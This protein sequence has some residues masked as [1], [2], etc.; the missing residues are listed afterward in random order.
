MTTTAPTSTIAPFKGDPL[1]GRSDVEVVGE[2]YG[3]L[4]GPQWVQTD[5]VRPERERLLAIGLVDVGVF[6]IERVAVGE[7]TLV[8]AARRALPF[9]L[10]AKPRPRHP[11]RAG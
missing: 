7:L 8:R 1:A 5:G 11:P 2:G 4:E 9:D 10:V 3:F 6:R